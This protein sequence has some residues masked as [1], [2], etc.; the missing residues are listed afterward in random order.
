M[1]QMN[2]NG[3]RCEP[4][5]TIPIQGVCLGLGIDPYEL[6]EF[7]YFRHPDLKPGFELADGTLLENAAEL[8]PR[9]WE[10]LQTE[11]GQKLCISEEEWQAMTQ[12]TWATLADGTKIGWDGIGGAP[13]YAPDLATGSLRLPDI[14][15]MYP[16]C[17]GFDGLSV[18][19]VHGDAIRQIAGSFDGYLDVR[20]VS[21]P[22]AVENWAAGMVGQ[23][24]GHSYHG[25]N[26]TASRVVPTANKNQPRAWG[27]LGCV[28]LGAPR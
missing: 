7:Y 6:C 27:A 15:G 14:R 18:G 16:E 23:S 8:Y 24:V 13:F 19:G 28:Y 26:F 11:A 2:E 21:G 4:T 25:I 10:Y 22:F 20:T 12:A 17:A 3:C 9:A 1:S 5:V